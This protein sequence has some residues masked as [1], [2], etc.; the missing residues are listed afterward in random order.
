LPFLREHPELLAAFRRGERAALERVYRH[1]VN[2]VARLLRLGFSS[3]NDAAVRVPGLHD[4]TSLLDALQEVFARAFSERARLSYDGLRPY[5]PF[6]LRIARNLRIDEL[7]AGG[8]ELSLSQLDDDGEGFEDRLGEAG[9][10]A[11]AA[12][13]L[14]SSPQEAREWQRLRDLTE[15]YLQSLDPTLKRFVEVRFVEAR[16]QAEVA[17]IMKITRRAVRT[18]EERV[19]QG[20]KRFLSARGGS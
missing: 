2:D 14:S 19:Q 3:G 9:T 1:Y 18:M 4:S 15:G 8:R 16:S 5:R 10:D 12:A 20:L 11:A 7:R 6:L 17:E 13:Q